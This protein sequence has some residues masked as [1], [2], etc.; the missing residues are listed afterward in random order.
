MSRKDDVP[1]GEI[2][3]RKNGKQYAV[4]IDMCEDCDLCAFFHKPLKWCST[5]KCAAIDRWD[6]TS[7]IFKEIK[8]KNTESQETSP[9]VL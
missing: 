1:V 6:K 7:V 5:M 8:T 3:T 9:E 2:L 4:L